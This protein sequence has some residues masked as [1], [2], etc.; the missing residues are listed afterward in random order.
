MKW[1]AAALI[2]LFAAMAVLSLWPRQLERPA[3]IVAIAMPVMPVMPPAQAVP[4]ESRWRL[5]ELTH[6]VPACPH[7]WIRHNSDFEPWDLH[8]VEVVQR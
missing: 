2:G 8:C 5:L 7:Q 4:Y 3:A 6:P 1:E